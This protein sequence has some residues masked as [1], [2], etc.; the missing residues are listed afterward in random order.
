MKN[1]VAFF[2]LILAAAAWGLGPSS[3]G[4]ERELTEGLFFPVSDYGP[5]WITADRNNDGKIDYAMLLNDRGERIFEAIDF[6]HD[7]YMDDFY[8]YRNDV[9]IRR[10]IDQSFNRSIDLWVYIHEGVYV[11]GYERDTSGDGK[12]DMY[13]AYGQQ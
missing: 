8:I 12:I 1:L 13:R 2:F 9:L 7:G 5:E 11:A 3:I 4:M 6:N 10:E